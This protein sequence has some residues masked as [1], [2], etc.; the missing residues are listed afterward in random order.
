MFGGVE[1]PATGGTVKGGPTTSSIWVL[2]IPTFEWVQLPVKSVSSAADPKARIAPECMSLGEHYVFYYGGR[3]AATF[4]GGLSC[5]RKANAAFLFDLNNLT[6]T[7]QY[8][9]RQGSYEI[10][11]PVYDLI[12]GE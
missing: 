9:P 7:D 12:G 10:P 5:D 3:N 8:E 4:Y 11:K 2:T 6:W 1:A